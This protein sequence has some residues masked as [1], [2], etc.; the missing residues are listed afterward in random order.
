MTGFLLPALVCTRASS[1]IDGAALFGV[2]LPEP[3]PM[4]RRPVRSSKSYSALPAAELSALLTLCAPVDELLGVA[5]LLPSTGAI[6]KS[7]VAKSSSGELAAAL[8]LWPLP[9]SN[10][11]EAAAREA[12]GEAGDVIGLVVPKGSKSAAVATAGV[13]AAEVS[14]A[15]GSKSAD[16]V[17]SGFD[18]LVA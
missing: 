13:G 8:A 11:S 6:V 15:K 10:G 1:A 4:V 18:S 12:A 14:A 5:A 2:V 16:A 7:S 9:M 17:P 3:P